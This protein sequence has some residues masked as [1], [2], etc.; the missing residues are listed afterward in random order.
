MAANIIASPY[1][2]TEGDILQ[3]KNLNTIVFSVGWNGDVNFLGETSFSNITLNEITI[4]EILTEFSGTVDD[5]QLITA[6]GVKDYLDA[7]TL[8][9]LDDVSTTPSSGQ[10]LS[11]NGSN[12]VASTPSEP[13]ITLSDLTDI[14]FSEIISDNQFLR[15][16][17]SNWVNETVN[18]VT[19]LNDL[20]DVNTA[21]ASSDEFLKYN[22]SSWIPSEF[23]LNNIISSG[24][25]DD[26]VLASQA[27]AFLPKPM[28]AKAI[29]RESHEF[30]KANETYD[31]SN[32]NGKDYTFIIG[33]YGCKIKGFVIHMDENGI[34][35]ASGNVNVKLYVNGTLNGT[36]F[37]DYNQTPPL[38]SISD[39]LNIDVG[40]FDRIT[41]TPSIAG[42]MT[43]PA[44]GLRA[45]VIMESEYPIFSDS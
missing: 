36:R 11:Y 41:L 37:I 15:Y 35:N 40:V 6:K 33:E 42:T 3:V 44:K 1:T 13:T 34:Y 30:F 18:L 29:T 45:T 22:G 39:E 7:L 38:C 5:T 16:D 4:S 23:P 8:N 24:S 27:G 32:I 12:W 21:G 43:T 17:G 20:N 9:D 25:S 10:I 31:E 26:D 19:T 2:L 28:Y 14:D